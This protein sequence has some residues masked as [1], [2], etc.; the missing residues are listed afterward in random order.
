LHDADTFFRVACN[1]KIFLDFF[2]KVLFCI[3]KRA[4]MALF[5]NSWQRNGCAV[6]RE[7]GSQSALI[8]AH[9]LGA[10]PHTT[11]KRMRCGRVKL[12]RICVRMDRST[13]RRLQ[14]HR[15]GSKAR[16]GTGLQQQDN[17]NRNS[18]L[19][20]NIRSQ[21][22]LASL[23]FASFSVSALATVTVSSPGNGAEVSSPFTLT[24]SAANCS[25]QVTAAMGYSLDASAD[26]TI[27]DSASLNAQ[28]P[29]SIGSHTLHVK[30]WGNG[31]AAC[32]TDVAITVT[33]SAS[34]ASSHDGISVTSPGAGAQVAS[35]FSLEASATSCSSQ[36]VG[37]MGYSIDNGATVGANGTT[38]STSVAASAGAHT[39][40]VKSWG[41]AG[42]GCD[43]DVAITVTGASG[44]ASGGITVSSPTSGEAVGTSFSLVADAAT[45]SSQTVVAMGYSLDN[46]ATTTVD[47]QSMAA[48]VT[49][50]AGAHTLH[51]KSWGTGGVG[52]DAD[53]AITAQGSG[54]SGGSGGITVS[55]PGNGA[56]LSSPFTLDASAS[57]CSSQPVGSMGYS[58]DSGGTVAVNGTTMNASVSTSSGAHTLH[59][60]SWGND[61]AGC[62]T[63]VAIT[64]NGG[65][66][67]P[68]SVVPSNALS[69]SSLQT[70][71]NWIEMN[72]SGESGTSG[73]AMGMV[74]SPS[75]SGNARRFQT[76]YTNGGGERYYVSFGDDTTSTNFFYDAYVY[77]ASPSGSLANVEMDMNQTMPNGQTAIFGFQC[78][79]YNSTWDVTKN[80]GSPTSPVD[81]WVHS[82]AYCNPRDWSTNTWHHVQVYYWRT[83]SGTITYETVWLDGAGQ[84]INETVPSAF[85]LGWAPT[86]LTNFQIDGIGSG[87]SMT[88]YLDKVT[89]YR[90]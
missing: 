60:K 9:L 43:A 64:V 31:G 42:A 77:I 80:A 33:G 21:I 6:Q 78:D 48:T 84:S 83:S 14:A 51:V 3:G 30:A 63:D 32:D 4:T 39:L 37:S 87:G 76:S 19:L 54:A 66:S 46:G 79:G 50:S 40:H 90:W 25:S 16:T 28:V 69:V 10:E 44:S 57:A 86:L 35:P 88:L 26:T 2:E 72:D 24:A 62:D 89:V 59:V 61:G 52:C 23:V 34:S 8:P 47:S 12:P 11:A 74:S 65:G 41:K 82:G 67:V 56:S 85:A 81:A 7:T 70:L 38:M 27:V 45:C 17:L 18:G 73:G 53:V 13:N 68:T 49:T 15:V 36:S 5:Q 58:I 20:M 55:S 29:A 22:F 71:G 75:L 1:L